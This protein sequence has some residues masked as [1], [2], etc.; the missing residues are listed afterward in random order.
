MT[1]PLDVYVEVPDD[2]GGFVRYFE[3]PEWYDRCADVC[4]AGLR[5]APNIYPSG[6]HLE[7]V[8]VATAREKVHRALIAVEMIERYYPEAKASPKG[9]KDMGIP[10]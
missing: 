5:N 8:A 10:V 2:F 9:P 7:G 4:K 6:A 3:A 1:L